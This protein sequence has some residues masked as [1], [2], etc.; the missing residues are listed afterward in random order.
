MNLLDALRWSLWV[1]PEPEPPRSR[2][3]PAEAAAV[4][5]RFGGQ[6]RRGEARKSIRAMTDLLRDDIAAG[7]VSPIAPT[8]GW[9]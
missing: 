2:V 8:Q 5:A 7:V 4:L 1:T 3:A 9:R 6:K